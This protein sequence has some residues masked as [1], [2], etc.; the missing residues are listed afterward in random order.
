MQNPVKKTYMLAN[1]TATT[2]I[3]PKRYLYSYLV[4]E[5]FANYH[6]NWWSAIPFL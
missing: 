4:G 2:E 5:V 6:K 3:V 1:S